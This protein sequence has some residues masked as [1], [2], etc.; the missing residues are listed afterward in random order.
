VASLSELAVHM[1]KT[2]F[3]G[4][5]RLASLGDASEADADL[6]ALANLHPDAAAVWQR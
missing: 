5:S 1:T 3:R 2:T 6:I 4:Y